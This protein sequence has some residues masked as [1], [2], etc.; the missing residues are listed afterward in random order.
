MGTDRAPHEKPVDRAHR[1]FAGSIALRD[2]P[3][4]TPSLREGPALWARGGSLRGTA[5]AEYDCVAQALAWDRGPDR[6]AGQARL[7]EIEPI[8]NRHAVPRH[9]L[10]LR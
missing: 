5:S 6:V 4:G 2:Q 7:D 8:D 9:P 10:A 3:P 1:A